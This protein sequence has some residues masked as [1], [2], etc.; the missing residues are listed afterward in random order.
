MPQRARKKNWRIVKVGSVTYPDLFFYTSK[1]RENELRERIPLPHDK[2]L[3]SIL[4]SRACCEGQV[5]HWLADITN[6]KL[7][8]FMCVQIRLYFASKILVTHSRSYYKS[9][10]LILSP[11]AWTLICE[12][13]IESVGRFNVNIIGKISCLRSNRKIPDSSELFIK[14]SQWKWQAFF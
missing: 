6:V 5:G 9:A 14:F 11:L 7:S 13:W 8:Y 3:K 4:S 1:A 10:F 2:Y 12:K